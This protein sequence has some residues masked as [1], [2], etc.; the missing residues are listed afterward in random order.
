MVGNDIIRIAIEPPGTLAPDSLKTMAAIL[1]KST[2][3]TQLLL[4]GQI[5]KIIAHY[6]STSLA[7][8]VVE[9]IRSLGI[10]VLAV[11]DTELH[12]SSPSFK[13]HTLE[14]VNKQILFQDRS[15]VVKIVLAN[16]IMLILTGKQEISI[17]SE[18]T[19]TKTKFNLTGTLLSG[20]IPMWHQV[21]EKNTIESMETK[22]FARLYENNSPGLWLELLQDQ[23]NYAFLGQSLAPSTF[24]NFNTLIRQL[25]DFFPNA[26]FDDRLTKPSVLSSSTNQPWQNMNITCKL[27]YLFHALAQ[28]SERS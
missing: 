19:T 9:Q 16:D 13:V 20:G 11:L 3:D 23:L 12:R 27:M 26:I 24:T 21:K 1:N 4:G 8:Q 28:K 25:R 22:F 6:D 17:V 5:P 18:T 14:N 2:W 7:D 10:K 15:G